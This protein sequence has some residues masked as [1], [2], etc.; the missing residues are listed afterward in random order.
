MKL[1]KVAAAVLN[2]TPRDWKGNK[3]NILEA[4]REA[5]KQNVKILC[6]PEATI[7]GY[8]M[9]D[10]Y[11]C[12]DVPARAIRKLKEIISTPTATGYNGICDNLVFC[13]GLPIRFN[14]TLYNAVATVVN[15]QVMGFTCK[16]HLAGDGIHYEQRWFKPWP[17]GVVQTI[18]IPELNYQPLPIGDIHFNIGGVKIG[19]EICEDAWVAN[20][21][22]T[23]LASKGVD[24][25]LNPSASHFS[26]GK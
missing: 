3:A 14:N 26:F 21:P 10:D 25:I 13:I 17:K 8:G 22:G 9:E 11:F 16:Q 4:I 23:I 20:R 1:L 15:G 18:K 2:Q 5:R 19:Y 12:D 7:T 6:L 24:I